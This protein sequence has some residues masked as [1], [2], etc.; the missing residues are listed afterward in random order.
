MQLSDLVQPMYVIF[1]PPN[2]RAALVAHGL[3]ALFQLSA[4]WPAGVV[5]LPAAQTITHHS[6]RP[7]AIHSSWMSD[8]ACAAAQGALAALVRTCSSVLLYSTHAALVVATAG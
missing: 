6:D 2:A 8:E 3:S 4:M 7:G 1:P 5:C